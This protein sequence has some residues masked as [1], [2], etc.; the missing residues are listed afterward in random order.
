VKHQQ[1]IKEKVSRETLEG[2]REIYSK[3]EEE[4]EKYIDLLLEWNSKINLVS[5]SVSRETVREH[6]THS[7]IPMQLGLVDEFDAWIDSGSGGGL[8]GA[9]LAIAN[10]EKHFYLNDNVKKKM[11][12]VS[13]ILKRGGIKNAETV[14]KSIS[15]VDLK[16]G[17]GIVTKHAFKIDDLLRL[18]GSKPWKT[19]IM[20]KGAEGAMKEISQSKKKLKYTLYEFD[21]GP[22]EEFY[23]GKA[24]LKIER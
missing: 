16:K 21:F 5:R 15:L 13:D 9:P 8:P 10:P 24:L 1:L 19:I 2:A 6:V 4:L 23:E 11:R 18:L 14:A 3:N 20:W 17:T 7:L 22:D 12:A